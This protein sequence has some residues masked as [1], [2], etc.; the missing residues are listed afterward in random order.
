MQARH[1]SVVLDTDI[2]IAALS[3]G[4]ADDSGHKFIIW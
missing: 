1:Y 3:V 2:Q 4:Q